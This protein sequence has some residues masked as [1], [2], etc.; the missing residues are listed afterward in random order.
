MREYD[1]ERSK[2]PERKVHLRANAKRWIARYP[3]RYRA[4]NAAN[5]AIRDGKMKRE[6]CQRCGSKAFVHKHHDDYAK[7]LDVVWLCA[8]C[9]ARE[10]W[11]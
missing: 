1:N 9:H 5:N 6:P 11:S 2:T 10:T 3:E 7:P 4:H 8:R